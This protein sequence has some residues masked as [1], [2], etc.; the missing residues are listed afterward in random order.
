MRKSVQK[1]AEKVLPNQNKA[2]VSQVAPPP[3]PK[4]FNPN[5]YIADGVSR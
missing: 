2:K 5:D 3:E 1:P 4:P